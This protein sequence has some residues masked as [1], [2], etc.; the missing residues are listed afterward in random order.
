LITD[1]EWR[2]CHES[3]KKNAKN[4]APKSLAALDEHHKIDPKDKKSDP[5]CSSA[6]WC[7]EPWP[8]HMKK[9]REIVE[10]KTGLPL[11]KDI[12]DSQQHLKD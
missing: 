9:E 3:F 5:I 1:D 11:D 12:R 7:G 6:G 2:K 4:E 10:Y 8:E